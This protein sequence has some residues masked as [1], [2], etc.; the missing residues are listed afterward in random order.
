MTIE[1]V[2]ELGKDD[3]VERGKFSAKSDVGNALSD[4]KVLIA[5]TNPQ[6]VALIIT[7]ADM[8]DLP[9]TSIGKS[10]NVIESFEREVPSLV[11]LDDYEGM[12]HTIEMCSQIR[13][14]ENSSNEK[15]PIILISEED[16]H[17]KAEQAGVTDW[18]VP[19]FTKEYARTRLRA[20]IMRSACRWKRASLAKNEQH[21]LAA[22]EEAQ[23]LDTDAEERFDRIT[24]IA[25]KL[26]NVPIALVSLVDKD[27]QWFKSCVGLDASETPRDQAFC[28]HAI[29][30]REPFI[31]RDTLLDDRFADNPL[32]TGGPKIRFYAGMP[33]ADT[34]GFNLGTLCIV[35][36]RPR[37]ISETQIQ[38][39][40]DLGKMVE[41][42]LSRA[43]AA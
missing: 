12:E 40:R 36:T 19:P 30:E 2:P 11:I 14:S 37:D 1:L 31:V 8:D 35:D 34:S 9:T 26:F 43:Q 16:D 22:L 38:E 5:A 23:I 4:H 6:N 18:L 10:E 41:E 32:V 17:K 13:K 42:Q 33:L 15:T 39:L 25:A 24:R 21:R 7:T 27:R 3:F 28:A 29:L 20:W